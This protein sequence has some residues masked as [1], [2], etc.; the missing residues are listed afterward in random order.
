[1]HAFRQGKALQAMAQSLSPFLAYY[2]APALDELHGDICDV[3][4]ANAAS[5]AKFKA[6]QQQVEQN[7]QL[8]QN[9]VSADSSKQDSATAR[10][11]SQGMRVT[12]PFS[13]VSQPEET[14][15]SVD[16]SQKAAPPP[17]IEGSTASGSSSQPDHNPFAQAATVSFSQ[18]TS[19]AP[20]AN[21][22]RAGQH[23]QPVSPFAAAAEASA[24]GFDT[25]LQPGQS[26]GHPS[27]QSAVQ[28]HR[29]S[30][31]SGSAQSETGGSVKS[32][33]SAASNDACESFGAADAAHQEHQ[34]QTMFTLDTPFVFK[35]KP[36]SSVH[37]RRYSTSTF[38]QGVLLTPQEHLSH[39]S[40]LST[41]VPV[42]EEAAQGEQQPQ[43]QDSP[44]ERQQLLHPQQQT[45]FV[46]D[47]TYA[48]V[49][50]QMRR[51][52]LSTPSQPA[53]NTLD[54]TGVQ[55]QIQV[56]GS[57]PG[58]LL[59]EVPTGGVT[60][61]DATGKVAA[62]KTHLAVQRQIN[63]GSDQQEVA[64]RHFAEASVSASGGGSPT[65]KSPSRFSKQ[66]YAS[67]PQIDADFQKPESEEMSHPVECT[68]ASSST[69]SSAAHQH[70]LWL[71]FANPNLEEEFGMWMGQKCSK[72]SLGYSTSLRSALL[73][74]SC[75][76]SAAQ[77]YVKGHVSSGSIL[78]QCT[79]IFKHSELFT[80]Q[81]HCLDHPAF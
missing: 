58:P 37:V 73:S 52:A 51:R 79:V 2:A 48:S 46:D 47:Y 41:M 39:L 38:Y 57:C 21:C 5:I 31:S 77:S 23:K 75:T 25:C 9:D 1:M 29:G 32:I 67:I 13:A 50:Q 8:V 54:L 16:Q 64:A 7:R 53:G 43:V 61:P 28:R 6:R 66:S 71:T 42:P 15:C 14:S 68:G 36:V 56:H 11:V 63:K 44:Q 69:T 27:D 4:S 49:A 72:V 17:R 26:Q 20:P 81:I 74:S 40:S 12:S 80:I 24:R 60:A 18:T 34:E 10:G 3:A 19:E 59:I 55:L 70:P 22:T 30:A 62:D 33:H 78:M 76:L 35:R 65:R 45:L